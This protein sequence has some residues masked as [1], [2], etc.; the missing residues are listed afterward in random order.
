M[1]EPKIIDQMKGNT[2]DDYKVKLRRCEDDL[3]VGGTGVIIL[4]AWDFLKVVMYGFTNVKNNL[5]LDEFT[6]EEKTIATVFAILLIAVILLLFF[7]VFKI[8]LYIGLNA[9]KAAKGEPYKKGYY[10]AAVILL[11]LFVT[12]M[13]AY[14]PE[15]KDIENIDN[16]IASFIVDLTTIYILWIVVSS[17]RKIRELRSLNSGE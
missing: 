9:S 2:M 15:L 6:G 16:T 13:F 17:T 14:I 11:I 1:T 12:G 8:H 4:G 3:N 7:F 10:K 5:N